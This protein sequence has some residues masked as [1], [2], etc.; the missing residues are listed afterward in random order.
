[1]I[2]KINFILLNIPEYILEIN[3]TCNP[4]IKQFF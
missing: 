3:E 1:M 2:K 4:K